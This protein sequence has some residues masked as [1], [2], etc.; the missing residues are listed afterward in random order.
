MNWFQRHLNW[1]LVLGL[2]GLPFIV[3]LILRAITF[4]ILSLVASRLAPSESSLVSIRHIIDF[5]TGAI[6]LALLLFGLIVTWWYLSKKKRSRLYLLLL[7]IP[8]VLAVVG[9]VLG[10]GPAGLALGY[11]SGML[12][13][14]MPRD[15]IIAWILMFLSEISIIVGF[16]WLLCLK[17]KALD[18]GG[19]FAAEAVTDRWPDSGQYG[20]VDDRQYK[21]LDYTPTQNV[22]DISGGGAAADVRNTSDVSKAVDSETVEA[23]GEEAPELEK[24]V[25]KSAGQ[26][27]LQ[28]P[29]LLDDAGAPISCFYHPGADAVNLC[30]RCG[31]YVCGECNYV[32]GTNPICRNCWDKR[33]SVPIAPPAQKQ[34][35][36]A[37]VKSQKQKGELLVQPEKQKVVEVAQ[38]E[39]Q[40][41]MEPAILEKQQVIEPTESVVEP[42]APVMPAEPPEPIVAEPSKP[43]EPE[44]VVPAKPEP[45][46][47][48]AS[49]KAVK[50]EAEKSEW[51]QEFMALYG[52][53]SP[54]IYA[55]TS[56]SPDGMP[57]S[58]LDLMEGLKLRPMLERAKKLSKPKD[59]ELREAK[60]DFE[61]LMSSCIKIADAA[62]NFISSGGQALLGGPNFKRIVDGIETANG[63]LEKLS[64]RLA[65]FSHPQE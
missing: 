54:I 3:N 35:K 5:V 4:G 56:K 31:Q 21:E 20:G 46:K 52:Q 7:V 50:Q 60:S 43:P 62:A 37:P 1:S 9:L 38:V 6:A 28:M 8:L 27:R 44:Y 25:E 26:Q 29:I 30:S 34:T 51:Q 65:A 23:D 19:D 11:L 17:N 16:I 61:Q 41:E 45:Q 53:A 63:L 13:G 12:M 10:G 57:A 49:E 14:E 59:K 39:A 18:Y 64:R 2:I 32:T 42:T 58:P 33:A 55:V 24:V 40:K 22:L 36:P 15:A 47:T 48:V